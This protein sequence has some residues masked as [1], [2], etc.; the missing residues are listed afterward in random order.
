[1]SNLRASSLG[2]SVEEVGNLSPSCPSVSSD[3]NIC[4]VPKV[5]W[6]TGIP[7]KEAIFFLFR[8]GDRRV[9]QSFG[10]VVKDEA[11]DDNRGDSV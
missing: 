6:W 8:V 9:V 4:A 3:C 7:S 2:S 10:F 11:G 1:M 5:A